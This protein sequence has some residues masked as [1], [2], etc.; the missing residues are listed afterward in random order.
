MPQLLTRRK[1]AWVEV[2]QP[3]LIKGTPLANPSIVQARYQEKLDALIDKMS[4]ITQLE[5]AKFF[6]EPH[7]Q[8]YFAMD[9]SVSSQAR[10]LTNYLSRRVNKLFA[11]QAPELAEQQAN[12]VDKASSNALHSS[13]QKLSGGLSLSTTTLAGPL[14]DI[15]SASITENVALIKSISQQYL[16]GV[17]GAVMRSIT[18][19]QGLH[20]LIPFLEK[21]KGITKRRAAM[22]ASDQTRKAYNNLNR[23]R[24]E[25]V[26]LVSFGWLHTG[27]S[28][29]PRKLHQ[30]YNGKIFRFDNLPIIDEDTGERGIPGQAINCHC[31]MFTVLSFRDDNE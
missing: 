17:Q 20:D 27:G 11:D 13:L 7:A 22:I 29:H 9:A 28:Q 18:T 24:M 4:E 15:L 1:Q 23:G 21:H 19:G 5:L 30:S 10:I 2:R 25:K 12:A 3:G 26:G 6:N 16:T 31:R 8:E 14:T